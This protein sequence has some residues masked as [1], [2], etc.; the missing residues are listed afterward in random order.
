[1]WHWREPRI[2]RY[3]TMRAL[4]P[5]AALLVSG[6]SLAVELWPRPAASTLC[7]LGGCRYDQLFT[8]IDAA[9]DDLK[10][11]K[12]LV[13]EDRAN[14]GVW[15]GYGELL[16][17]KGQNDAAARAFD[18]A[19]ALGPGM[20][21]VLMRAA[22]FDFTHDRLE[23]ALPLVPRILRATESFDQLLFSYLD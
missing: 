23:Q 4:F 5:V 21:P 15:C 22:D 8:Q 6:F 16:A 2:E 3:L 19:L 14:P 10:S 17:S 13:K 7:R 20:A 9:G 12:A 1:R 18:R 11:V